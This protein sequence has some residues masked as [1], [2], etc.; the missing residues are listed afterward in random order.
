MTRDPYF[1]DLFDNRGGLL[2]LDRLFNK[3]LDNFE[4]PPINVK[5]L[6][7]T[8]ELELAAPGLTKDDFNITLD[9]GVLT[10]SSEKEQKK[11]EDQNGYLRREFSYNSFTR[12]FN[13]PETIDE[14]KE[15]KATYHN[16]ILKLILS[17][18]ENIKPKLPK[19]VKV[20]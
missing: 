17:K 4:I 20:S 15:V 7:E 3:E 10:I 11:E 19:S 13:L 1:I 18:N 9:N 6:K 12:S 14:N 2:N 8:L 16:G 5:D